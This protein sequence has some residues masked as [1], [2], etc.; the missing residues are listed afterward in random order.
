MRTYI[1]YIMA[2]LFLPVGVQAQEVYRTKVYRDDIKSPEVKVEGELISTPFIELNGKDR[3]EIT[4]DALH[5]ATG[6]YAYSVIHCDADWTQSDL[7]PIE[8]MKGFQREVIQDYATAIGTTTHYTNYKLSLPNE[9]TQLTVSGNYAIRIFEEDTPGKAVITACFSIVEPLV[10]IEAGV[11]GNTDIDF[12][13]EHQQVEFTIIPKNIDIR[14]PQ[15]D[16]KV[17]V[18]QNNNLN[19][20]RANLQPTMIG[21]DRLQYR[22]NR[23]LIFEAGNEYRR[24]E[25]LTHRYKDLGIEEIGF[26]NPYYHLTLYKEKKRDNK[27]YLYDQDQNGRFFIRCIGCDAPDTEGDYYVI[28]FSL[29]SEP[30]RNGKMYLYGDFFNNITDNKSLMEYNPETGAFEK[31]VLLKTGVYNYQYVFVEDGETKPSFKQTEGNFFETEN[32]YTITVYYRPIGARYDRLI[33][34]KTINSQQDAKRP[35]SI[36]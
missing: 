25:F 20:V 7:I 11:S 28:H 35:G 17:F 32:E 16:L 3:I 33:G 4:F 30:M 14:Y 24:I 26:Y 18:N 2:C 34:H 1:I 8:Y 5:H 19:D 31:P 21:N 22:N 9:E 29:A 13:R 27:T 12:N 10:E 23:D 6:R 15:T 36:L